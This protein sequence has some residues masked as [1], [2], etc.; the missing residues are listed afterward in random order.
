VPRIYLV[1]TNSYVRIARRVEILGDHGEHHL[2]LTRQLAGECTHSPSLRGKFD[3]MH[4]APHPQR[5]EKWTL[6]VLRDAA[7]IRI[8]K[9]SKNLL[10]AAEDV[11]E[12]YREKRLA[13]GDPRPVLSPV[14]ESVVCTAYALGYGVITDEGPIT[15]ICEEFDI[16]YLGTLHALAELHKGAFVPREVVDALVVDWQKD[17]DTP[18]QWEKIYRALFGVD[19]PR[20]VKS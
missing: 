2:R 3:W 13:R 18:K 7:Q 4:E 9:K 14:D 12:E 16:P 6:P 5:R 11:L 19:P 15:A 20:P 17:N 8:N 10:A 1:D